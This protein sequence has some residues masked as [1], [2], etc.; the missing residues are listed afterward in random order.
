TGSNTEDTPVVVEA[1][2]F[3][4]GIVIAQVYEVRPRLP[5]VDIPGDW[6]DFVVTSPTP[7]Y[8]EPL[9][10]RNPAHISEIDILMA[11]LTIKGIYAPYEIDRLNHGIGF[12]TA[13]IE[14]L[15]PTYA[16]ALG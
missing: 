5:R 9:F 2:A 12:N 15:L 10:T 14:L 8:I 13:A 16:A 7:Y 4:N 1:T 11:M 3:R 6:I